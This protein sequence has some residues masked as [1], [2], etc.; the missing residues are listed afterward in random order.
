MPWP[1]RQAAAMG[2]HARAAPGCPA[3]PTG[4]WGMAGALYRLCCAA[5][6]LGAAVVRA[7]PRR[8]ALRRYLA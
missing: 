2:W 3:V 5:E 4:L 1:H 6:P 7:A 8:P